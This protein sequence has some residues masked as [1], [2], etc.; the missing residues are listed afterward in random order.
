MANPDGLEASV[1][2]AVAAGVPVITINSG[3]DKFKEFGA[4]THIGQTETIAGEAVG[5]R[6]E[7]RGLDERHLRHPGGRQRRSRGALQ[8]RRRGL[9]RHDDEPAG[10]RHGRRRGRRRPSRRSCRPTRPSTPSLT[11]GGQYAIDAVGAVEESG[12]DAKV[13]H[14]R[15]VRGRHQGHP[16]RQ[17]SC[18]RSTSS[19]TSR[20]SWASPACYLSRING[21]DIG[22]GQPI[23]SGPAFVTKDNATQVAEVRRE[24]HPLTDRGARPGR[25]T[26]RLSAPADT[27]ADHDDDEPPAR[28]ATDER[29]AQTSSAPQLLETPRDGRARRRPRR[30]SS[31]SPLH[32]DVFATP[33]GAGTWLAARRP[34]ASWPSRWPC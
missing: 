14:L 22:G 17:R 27:G 19:P 20:A 25:T 4:I 5:E 26:R 13:A 9:R 29:V 10:R 33:R 30:S 16:G 2:K 23:Y 31:S 3:V 1:K 24:R 11:L 12:S 18:S 21:N 28:S 8:G 6:L 15:P 32:D 7:D 34:S